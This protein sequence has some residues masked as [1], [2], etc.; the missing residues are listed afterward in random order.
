M[1]VYLVYI[2]L[3]TSGNSFSCSQTAFFP[4]WTCSSMHIYLGSTLYWNQQQLRASKIE[5]PG[6]RVGL[7]WKPHWGAVR[8][9][10][11]TYSLLGSA[12]AINSRQRSE[13]PYW[14]ARASPGPRGWMCPCPRGNSPAH[15]RCSGFDAGLLASP[16]QQ[17][18]GLHSVSILNGNLAWQHHFPTSSLQHRHKYALLNVPRQ[19]LDFL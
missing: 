19:Q 10:F 13:E 14:G 1:C 6:K 5:Q 8:S 16:I 2:F 3:R 17:N 12:P 11:G 15:L 7:H 9:Q 4:P 18:L